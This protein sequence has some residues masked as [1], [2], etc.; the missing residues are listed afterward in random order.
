[1]VSIVGA[2]SETVNGI[3][4]NFAFGTFCSYVKRFIRNKRVCN[5]YRKSDLATRYSRDNKAY[6]ASR[7]AGKKTC[8]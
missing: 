2:V 8:S 1:M 5:L 6:T 4:F 7:Q 3:H